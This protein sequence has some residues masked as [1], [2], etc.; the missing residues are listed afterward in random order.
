MELKTRL[1]QRVNCYSRPRSDWICIS[2]CNVRLVLIIHDQF[3]QHD[4]LIRLQIPSI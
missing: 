4:G 3:G 2:G 1:N